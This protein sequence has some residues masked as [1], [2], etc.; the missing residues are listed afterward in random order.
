MAKAAIQIRKTGDEMWRATVMTASGRMF[1]CDYAPADEKDGAN[2]D[3][4]PTEQMVQRD[5]S[6]V[7]DVF[8]QI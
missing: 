6:T 5:W 7:R 3:G 8:R 1:V 2:A 4:S